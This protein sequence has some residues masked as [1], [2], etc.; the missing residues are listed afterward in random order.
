[1]RRRPGTEPAA[2]LA[3]RFPAAAGLALMALVLMLGTLLLLGG[4]AG[5]F[6]AKG[7][8]SE[9]GGDAKSKSTSRSNKETAY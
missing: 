5:Y 1:M 2:I 4:A 8:E 9:G 7:A 3:G 6:I